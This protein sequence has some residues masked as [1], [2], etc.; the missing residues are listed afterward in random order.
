MHWN[1]FVS[2]VR[3]LGQYPTEAEAVRVSRTVLSALG[4]QVT[5]PE[6]VD[7][8]ARLPVEAAEVLVGQVPA[9]RTLT[10]S[11]F[12]DSVATRLDD[13]TPATARWDVSS[14][15]CVVAEA[16]GEELTRRLLAELPAGFALLF[17]KAELTP[18]A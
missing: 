16:A 6:R 13:A 18:A 10:A 15:L 4:G 2:R 7:L 1:E 5:G 3:E 8:A 12:V 17:G 9:T 11:R 14:V